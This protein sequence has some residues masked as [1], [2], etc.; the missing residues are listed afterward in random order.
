MHRPGLL[1]QELRWYFSFGFL[2]GSYKS[3][4]VVSQQVFSQWHT[5]ITVIHCHVSPGA[6][7]GFYKTQD[8]LMGCVCGLQVKNIYNFEGIHTINTVE[9]VFRSTH[10]DMG[11]LLCLTTN[12]LKGNPQPSH[13][14]DAVC[15]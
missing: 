15:A 6:R 4:S 5:S 1:W 7:Y 12:S 10:H 14:T 2:Q 13:G 8:N 11:T 3:E 9:S